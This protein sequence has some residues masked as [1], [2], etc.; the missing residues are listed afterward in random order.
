MA[1]IYII[2]IFCTFHISLQTVYHA[3]KYLVTDRVSQC[4]QRYDGR[5]LCLVFV[6]I[7]V[8][9]FRVAM[10]VEELIFVGWTFMSTICYFNMTLGSVDMNVHPTVI[11]GLVDMNV[12]PTG[13]IGLGGHE[14]PPYGV[15]N[16]C[17]V[18]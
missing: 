13:D 14:C 1:V 3:K 10:F 17:G 5:T 6:I 11:L 7:A 16:G 18:L 9:P 2:D 8:A 4:V 15:V 12:Y